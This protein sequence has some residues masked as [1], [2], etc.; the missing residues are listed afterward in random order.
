MPDSYHSR[1]VRTR[2][3]PKRFPSPLSSRSAQRT[4]VQ[5]RPH[6]ETGSC[7]MA[8][9][10]PVVLHHRREDGG[11]DGELSSATLVAL[12]A[13]VGGPHD[14]AGAIE[15]SRGLLQS[16]GTLRKLSGRKCP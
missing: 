13:R 15:Q 2:C 7:Q 6:Q 8:T 16:R 10:E 14:V 1:K 9:S 11:A 4:A 5:L 12:L 3:P